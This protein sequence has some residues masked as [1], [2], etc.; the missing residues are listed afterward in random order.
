LHLRNPARRELIASTHRRIVQQVEADLK[1]TDE[2]PTHLTYSI[3]NEECRVAVEEFEAY[4]NATPND[5]HRSFV[6]YIEGT[7]MPVATRLLKKRWTFVVCD[8]PVFVTG[9]NPISLRGPNFT[10]GKVGFGTQG[11]TV[12]FP[13]SPHVV[14]HL[15]DGTGFQVSALAKSP[16]QEFK[17]WA[18]YNYEMW[19]NADRFI[20]SPRDPNGVLGEIVEFYEHAKAT[21]KQEDV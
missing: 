11:M 5:N 1:S 6:K 15:D 8:D 21:H 18:V 10:G 9:D 7:A 4:K 19:T 16:N 20:Y 14:L 3:D 12:Q 2:P 13:V 17:P